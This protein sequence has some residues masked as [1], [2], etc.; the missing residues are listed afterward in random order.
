MVRF[1][2]TFTA[3]SSVE[4][5]FLLSLLPPYTAE[6]IFPEHRIHISSCDTQLRVC[7]GQAVLSSK[8]EFTP[9]R[10]EKVSVHNENQ[11]QPFER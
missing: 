5:I 8:K 6:G 3:F 10:L 4:Q 11:I 2:E 7:I 9:S 1:S